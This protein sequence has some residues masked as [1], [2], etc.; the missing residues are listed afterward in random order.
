MHPTEP[1]EPE[2]PPNNVVDLKKEPVPPTAEEIFQAKK[3]SCECLVIIHSL[4][5]DGLF[6]GKY[7]ATLQNA[8]HFV[9]QTH[10]AALA[11]YQKDP[12]FKPETAKDATQENPN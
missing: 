4:L 8:K 11:E 7:S 12:L 9:E 2:T 10:A 6:P 1:T 3:Q 5:A